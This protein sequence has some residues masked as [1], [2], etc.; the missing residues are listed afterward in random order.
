MTKIIWFTEE[1]LDLIKSGKQ[2]ELII[3]ERGEQV[4]YWFRL[5]KSQYVS[6][7]ELLKEKEK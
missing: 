7:A 3:K 4:V 5:E 2:V 6:I 1:E